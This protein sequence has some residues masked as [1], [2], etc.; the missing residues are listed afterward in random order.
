MRNVSNVPNVS[1]V[2]YSPRGQSIEAVHYIHEVDR[3]T[4]CR[5]V[6]IGNF[7]LGFDLTGISAFRS[8]DLENPNLEPNI[9]WIG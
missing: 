9:T 4:R 3:L 8:A 7:H 5:D 6:A 1:T 2:V